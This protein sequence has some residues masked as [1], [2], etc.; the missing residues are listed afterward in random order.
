MCPAG[1][2]SSSSS[3]TAC[4]SCTVGTYS[5]LGGSACHICPAG[6]ISYPVDALFTN[7]TTC[8]LCPA[9]QSSFAGT[10]S[11]FI[12]QPGSA[13]A[14]DGSPKCTICTVGSYSNRSGATECSLCPTASYQNVTSGTFCY[15]CYG[16]STTAAPG[17]SSVSQC[18]SLCEPGQAGSISAIGSILGNLNCKTC[19]VGKFSNS[20]RQLIDG[21]GATVCGICSAGTQPSIDCIS[22]L[23]V[24]ITITDICVRHIFLDGG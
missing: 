6:T 4:Q 12:C 13:S 9:G 2:Y 7:R 16:N 8:L 18:V 1:K 22:S 24:K 17:A 19:S 5:L 14:F 10:T 3:S 15:H 20:S 21:K 11:C 23:N